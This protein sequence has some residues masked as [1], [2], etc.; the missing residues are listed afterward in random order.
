MLTVCIVQNVPSD[1]KQEQGR[2]LT[3]VLA[4]VE[5]RQVPSR[6]V[7]LCS[8]VVSTKASLKLSYLFSRLSK[9]AVFELEAL[10]KSDVLMGV[11]LPTFTSLALIRNPQVRTMTAVRQA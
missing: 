2:S 7:V 6:V 11:S 1:T 4:T 10:S 8:K 3:D 5:I 9:I